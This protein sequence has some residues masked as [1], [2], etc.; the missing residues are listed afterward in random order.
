VVDP[1]Q[2]FDHRDFC[3][4]I[5]DGI[6]LVDAAGTIVWANGAAGDVFGWPVDELV[7]QAVEV[8]IPSELRVGHVRHRSIYMSAPQQRLYGEPNRFQ[9]LHRDGTPF[10]TQI[11]LNPLRAGDDVYVIVAVRDMSDWLA[12]EHGLAVAERR[13]ALAE[14]RERIARNLHDT[15]IQELFGLGMGMQSWIATVD[16]GP[17][18][19]CLTDAIN[20][21]DAIIREIRATIFGLRE[22]TTGDPTFRAALDDLV[23]AARSTLGFAPV[24]V[25][26]PP[27]AEPPPVVAEHL[28]PTVR[29]ALSNVM[30]H[31]RASSLDVRV[32]IDDDAVRLTVADDGIGMPAARRH[33]GGLDNLARRAAILGGRLTVSPREGGGTVLLWE[34]PV[35]AGDDHHGQ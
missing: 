2:L 15:V 28:L 14:E 23:E 31:A 3:E 1:L 26:E 21:I 16:A 24:L 22:P 12:H 7:G 6:L 29:E 8:L 27:D 32:Q 30:K 10:V 5:P 18:R 19:Q 35:V 11:A 4:A 17:A 33:V 25:V 34:V 13:I 9:A 20:S